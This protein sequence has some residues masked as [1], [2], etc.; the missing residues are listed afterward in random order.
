[1]SFTLDWLQNK[2][3]LSYHVE[4]LDAHEL[5]KWSN[6]IVETIQNWQTKSDYLVLFNLSNTEV[7]MPFLLLTHRDVFNVGLTTI[8]KSRI[9][10]HLVQSK[11]KKIYLALVFSQSDSSKVV[12]SYQVDTQTQ[13]II[14]KIF[15]D[16]DTAIQWLTAQ[17]TVQKPLVTKPIGSRDLVKIV[18]SVQAEE[19]EAMI[20]KDTITLL[21]NNAVETVSF[22][23]SN[24]A[25][26]G[27]L[28]S[29]SAQQTTQEIQLDLSGY[30]YDSQSISRKHAMLALEDNYLYLTDLQSTNG[31]FI[32][33]V[34]LNP[35]IPYLIKPTDTITFGTLPV[36]VLF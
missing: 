34:R 8:G 22:S 12:T 9:R 20:F 1:M 13:N 23:Q 32:S 7:S 19:P 21:V 17:T 3:I 14:G 25:I 18:R 5:I 30:G 28:H 35:G 16:N 6:N 11:N 4:A 24:R 29:S 27:R 10:H 2:Q 31:T 26:V 15:F 33:G 36:N